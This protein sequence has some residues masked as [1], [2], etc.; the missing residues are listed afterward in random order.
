MPRYRGLVL[1]ALFLAAPA[2]AQSDLTGAWRVAE[3]GAWRSGVTARGP[4]PED[5]ARLAEGELAIHLSCTAL[6]GHYGPQGIDAASVRVEAGGCP[7][8]EADRA[9]RLARLMNDPATVQAVVGGDLVLTG[10][11]GLKARLVRIPGTAGPTNPALADPLRGVLGRWR[12]EAIDGRAPERG[13][14]PRRV[15][16]LDLGPF[17]AGAYTGCNSGGTDVLWETTSFRARGPVVAD[18]MGCGPLEAQERRIFAVLMARPTLR[19][20]GDRLKMLL[21]GEEIITLS[22]MADGL[23]R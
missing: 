11:D 12:I 10:L 13:M 17:A 5:E 22:R 8:G 7:G 4:A 2:L 16:Y 6:S 18:A 21:A 3:V 15:P 23:E 9:A 1:L 14:D 20:E 19:L